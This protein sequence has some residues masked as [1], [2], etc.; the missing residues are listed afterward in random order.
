VGES[1]R[2][3]GSPNPQPRGSCAGGAPVDDEDGM[4]VVPYSP[5]SRGTELLMAHCASLAAL[6]LDPRAPTASERLADA[7]GTELAHKLVFALS[8]SSP[9]RARFA[10]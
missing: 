2:L 6:G 8:T 4:D 1:P 10:A 3:G 5:C 7:V 9:G